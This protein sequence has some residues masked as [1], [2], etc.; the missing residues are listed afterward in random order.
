ME[1][2]K[3]ITGYPVM[4]AHNCIDAYK[5]PENLQDWLN[6]PCCKLKPKVWLFDNGRS[7]ACGCW[8]S[9]YDYFSINAESIGSVLH[10]TGSL[11]EYD[12]NGLQKNWNHWCETGEVLFQ[13]AS[14]RF[15]GRW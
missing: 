13:H 7:T 2:V 12:P 5:D 10:R 14:N 6:C 3:H 4:A 8:K 1:N 15:E 9:K 11:V